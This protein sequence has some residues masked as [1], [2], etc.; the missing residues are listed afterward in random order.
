MVGTIQSNGE[1]ARDEGEERQDSLAK[2]PEHTVHAS[3]RIGPVLNSCLKIRSLLSGHVQLAKRLSELK[4][5][6]RSKEE[7]R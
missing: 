3:I 4:T 6:Y 2:A 5:R 1:R 7:E